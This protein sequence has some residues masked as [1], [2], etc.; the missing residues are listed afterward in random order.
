MSCCD[1]YLPYRLL[2]GVEQHSF[3]V[4]TDGE[5]V[6]LSGSLRTCPCS[7][8]LFWNCN[9]R[10]FD[11]LVLEKDFCPEKNVL[12]MSSDQTGQCY[13]W[14]LLS[15]GRL[16]L[17]NHN[18]VRGQILNLTGLTF[19]RAFGNRLTLINKWNAA[20][21]EYRSPCVYKTGDLVMFSGVM[22]VSGTFSSHFAT[23]PETYRPP[24]RQRYAVPAANGKATVEVW[25]NGHCFVQIE[26]LG[27]ISLDGIRYK[28]QPALPPLMLIDNYDNNLTPINGWENVGNNYAPLTVSVCGIWIILNGAIK[29]ACENESLENNSLITQIP[30]QYAPVND[31]LFYSNSSEDD[32]PLIPIMIHKNGQI[33]YL[34]PKNRLCKITLSAILFPRY[35]LS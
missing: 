24:Y 22:S 12:M 17:K 29:Y 32:Y 8:A 1:D 27:F 3:I 11:V 15:N 4:K 7:S 26:S 19:S 23:L 21:I 13:H 28:T 35:Y 6:V 25:P 33:K 34:G 31:L 9:Y 20:S 2:T 18:G 5:T 14:I 30:L 10:A 16:M